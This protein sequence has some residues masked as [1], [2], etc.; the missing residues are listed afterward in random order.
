MCLDSLTE[1]PQVELAPYGG[2][3]MRGLGYS[4]GAAVLR[5]CHPTFCRG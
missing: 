3:R 4:S 5:C 1:Q 2:L